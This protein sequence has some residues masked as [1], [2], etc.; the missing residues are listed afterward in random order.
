MP[1]PRI[2]WSNESVLLLAWGAWA[3]ACPPCV[4][5]LYPIPAKNPE[6][7]NLGGLSRVT[8]AL[9]ASDKDRL[10]L[11]LPDSAIND[12]SPREYV[13]KEPCASAGD[14]HRIGQPLPRLSG[15]PAV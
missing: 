2:D 14:R 8:A 1:A 11:F 9:G 6:R 13:Q 10:S 7:Q 12:S 5:S 3:E 15:G 4:L